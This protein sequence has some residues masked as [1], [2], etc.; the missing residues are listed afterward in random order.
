MVYLP[1]NTVWLRLSSIS[2]GLEKPNEN[3]SVLY[4]TVISTLSRSVAA[5]IPVQTQYG[6]E[7]LTISPNCKPLKVT[8][9]STLN[10][11]KQ[12]NAF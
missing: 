4:E 6:Y 7:L 5:G 2:L 10:F 3:K 1:L 11:P 12:F 9:D 8:H